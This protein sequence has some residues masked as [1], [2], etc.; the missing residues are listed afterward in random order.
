MTIFFFHPVI[1]ITKFKS[2]NRS[3][4]TQNE[5]IGPFWVARLELHPFLLD[6]LP[7]YLLRCLQ[8]NMYSHL[9]EGFP[10]CFDTQGFDTDK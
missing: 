5:P 7:I 10:S 9:T 6:V 3:F 1:S 4:S 8:E 2:E